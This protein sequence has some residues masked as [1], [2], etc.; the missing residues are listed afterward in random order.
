[1]EDKLL[2]T[3]EVIVF[4]LII[5]VMIIHAY[6]KEIKYRKELYKQ[7]K[8]LERHCNR[9]ALNFGMAIRDRRLDQ[10]EAQLW[11]FYH[12]RNE[13]TDIIHLVQTMGLNNSEWE[14]LKEVYTITN[15]LH[16]N[17]IIEIDNYFKNGN[18]ERS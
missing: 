1:M 15:Y 6:S 2:F 7:N 13:N 12:G 5:M 18:E 16:E 11:G 10:A 17:E 4:L 8:N 3:S 14:K 9:Y